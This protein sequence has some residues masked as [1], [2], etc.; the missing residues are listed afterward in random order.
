M[1][2][3]DAVN[4]MKNTDVIEESGQRDY[5]ENIM[6]MSNITPKTMNR[7]HRYHE[8]NR[9]KNREISKQYYEDNKKSWKNES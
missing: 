6:M 1:N 7:Q 2:K 4:R 9:K 3:S 8:E 5:K